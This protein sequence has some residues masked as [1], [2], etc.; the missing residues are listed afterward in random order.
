MSI[1]TRIFNTKKND[2]PQGERLPSV[3]VNYRRRIL[4]TNEQDVYEIYKNSS[5]IQSCV[6]L[7][8]NEFTS[9]PMKPYIAD[10]LYEGAH[11]DI[12]SVDVMQQL[13][14]QILLSG[15]GFIYKIRNAN[16]NLINVQILSGFHVTKNYDTQ[17]YLQDWSYQTANGNF[18]IPK[19]DIVPI[20]WFTVSTEDKD[21]G[22]SPINTIIQQAEQINELTR[23]VT[24]SAANDFVPRTI[25]SAP[26][27]MNLTNAQQKQI[28]DQVREEFQTNPGS[29]KVLNGGWTIERLSIGLNE[30]D[31][32]MLRIVPEADIC[33]SFMIPPTILHT[34]AGM[35]NSTYN[36]VETSRKFFIQNT[37]GGMWSRV[38][39]VINDNFSFE[40]PS[41]PKWNFETA[42]LPSMKEDTNDKFLRLQAMFQANAISRAE[43]RAEMD[44]ED[45]DNGQ[46]VYYQDLINQFTF[47]VAEQEQ[48][49]LPALEQAD[50]KKP[51]RV[52]KKKVKSLT[53]PKN[54]VETKAVFWR[55]YNGITNRNSNAFKEIVD[56]MIDDMKSRTISAVGFNSTFIANGNLKREDF[57]QYNDGII[58][59]QEDIRRQLAKD[60]G[61]AYDDVGQLARNELQDIVGRT[62]DEMFLSMEKMIAETEQ[63][64]SMIR[65]DAYDDKLELIEQ[66]F[67]KFKNVHAPA[68][69]DYSANNVATSTQKIVMDDKGIKY[70]WLTQR[71]GRVRASH[72]AIDGQQPDE[73]GFFTLGDGERTKRPS[74]AGMTAKNSMRCRCILYPVE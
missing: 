55:R 20:T 53:I 7:W 24:D 43:F 9:A 5:L 49:E 59:A 14:Y 23:F 16:G 52:S 57:Q 48:P 4:T 18:T 46:E 50:A 13:V 27:N 12:F 34:V 15:T 74:D 37:V 58:K 25:L 54:D 73:S 67:Q 8:T 72:R 17:G 45:I 41:Q 26:P 10:K 61:F 32:Q 36:N 68:I 66:K 51:K 70:I 40:F 11:L 62:S 47:G 30:L 21:F 39:Q 60:L 1:F 56:K 6:N 65:G 2:I 69:A 31:T 64:L 44:L 29:I 35:Q 63:E 38:E 22:I 19:D 71:D 28:L 33:G 3:T 42:D